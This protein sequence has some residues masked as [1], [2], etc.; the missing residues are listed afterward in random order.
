MTDKLR[1]CHCG[2]QGVKKENHIYCSDFC[3]LF[4]EQGL[5]KV[6]GRYPAISVECSFCGEE[7]LA[8]KGTGYVKQFC[9]PACKSK[10]KLSPVRR[11]TMNHFML[12]YLKRNGGW[13]TA[14]GL[15][16]ILSRYGHQGN[17]GR[18][19]GLLARWVRL[20]AVEMRK[21][22]GSSAS[23]YRFNPQVKTP[24]AKIVVQRGV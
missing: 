3:R 24:V 4:K 17:A 23:E 13:L 2:N 22:E 20:G 16:N 6:K 8:R 11:P 9:S 19:S 21:A 5:E 15:T 10:L 18:W 1:L 7:S 12:F 14:Q